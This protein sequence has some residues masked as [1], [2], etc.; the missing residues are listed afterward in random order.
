MVTVI[1]GVGFL[2]MLQLLTAGTR[3]NI[4][5]AM[6]TTGMSLAKNVRERTVQ[7]KFE[8]VSAMNGRT[9]QPAIDS[10]GQAVTEMSEWSQTVAVQAVNVANLTAAQSGTS[11][12]SLK[13]TVTVK[14]NAQEVCE[15]SWCLFSPS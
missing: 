13:V 15:L 6:L 14:H 12:Q 3:T 7:I 1:I 9:F 2:G 5:G 4:D 8:D 11:A 10:R